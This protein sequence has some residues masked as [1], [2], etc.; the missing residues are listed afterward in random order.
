MDLSHGGDRQPLAE[1]ADAH[2]LVQRWRLILEAGR[3]PGRS[4]ASNVTHS[5]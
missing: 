5:E 2:A 1:I 4:V 3:W